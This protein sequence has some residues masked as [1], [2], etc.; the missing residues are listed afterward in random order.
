[1]DLDAIFLAY[2]IRGKVPEQLNAKTAYLIGKALADFLPTKGAVAVGRDMRPDSGELTD[3]LVKGL[4]EQ[5]RD[6]IDIGQVTSDMIYFAVGSLNLA[7]GAM[8]TASHNPGAYNGIKLVR[9]RAQGI[10]IE[11]GLRDI[12]STIKSGQFKPTAQAGTLEQKQII[13]AWINHVLGFV[14]DMQLKPLKIAVDAG[15]GMAGAIVPHL[16]GKVPFKITPLYF[17]LD[18]TFPNH[19]A[20]PLKIETLKDLQAKVKELK[21]DAGVAF[22]GD[23]DRA[24]LVDEQGQPVPGSIMTALLAEYFLKREPGS[25]ILYNLICSRIVPETIQQ[26][27]GTAVRTRVGHTFIKNDMRDNKALFAG[28]HSSHFYFRDNYNA[29]SG[30]IAAMV[31]LGILSGS[32]Q[33]LSQL[34]QKYKK[35]IASGEINFEVKDKGGMMKKIAQQFKDGQ[36]DWLDGLTVQ[37][38]DWWFN[39]RPSNTEPLLRLNIEAN[40]ED[41]VDQKTQQIEAIIKD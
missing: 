33:K 27:G 36:Q 22:D 11:S 19:E 28:E 24:V 41:E 14:K 18:G 32:G 2:D 21:L 7:G 40:T 38:S 16:E 13:D 12:K 26:L 29:D 15:N 8:I 4:L 23:G 6:V 1:M 9:E 25:T 39:V 31:G 20:N 3:N 17:E 35:Y 10:S 37:Y 5:G 30:L 34:V